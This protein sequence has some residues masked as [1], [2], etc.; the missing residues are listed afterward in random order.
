MEDRG[1]KRRRQRMK[2]R[3]RERRRGKRCLLVRGG[4]L[5]IDFSMMASGQ[6]ALRGDETRG[7]LLRVAFLKRKCEYSITG[8]PYA[9]V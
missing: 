6:A 2:K 5:R 9:R 1:R 7:K 3:E 8:G 4:I